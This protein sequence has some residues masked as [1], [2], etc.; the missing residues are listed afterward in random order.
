M[1]LPGRL[2]CSRARKKERKQLVQ[3]QIQV[4]DTE[5]KQVLRTA[6]QLVLD[7]GSPVAW[8]LAGVLMPRRLLRKHLVFARSLVRDVVHG[9]P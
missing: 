4:P 9:G 7:M 3:S 1:A 8:G 2:W 6:N 5:G